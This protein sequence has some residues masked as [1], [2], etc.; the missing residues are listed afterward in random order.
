MHKNCT[1]DTYLQLSI[2]VVLDKLLDASDRKVKGRWAVLDQIFFQLDDTEC[3]AVFRFQTKELK[4]T[5]IVII[6]E[7]NVDKEHLPMIIHR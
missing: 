5:K 3:R 1:V 2:E 6:V 7:I 4:N